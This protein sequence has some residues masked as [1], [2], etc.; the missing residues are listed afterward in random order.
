[1]LQGA[2]ELFHRKPIYMS[3]EQKEKSFETKQK[4]SKQQNK[5]VQDYYH[6]AVCQFGFGR[7]H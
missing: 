6:L 2:I 4:L 7:C 1:M 5:N 3:V